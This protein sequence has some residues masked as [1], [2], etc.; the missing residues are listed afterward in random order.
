MEKY[1]IRCTEEQTRKAFSLGAPIVISPVLDIIR[2]ELSKVGY[3]LDN[4][5]YWFPIAEQMLG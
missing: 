4:S 3:I 2:D 1:T 5:V